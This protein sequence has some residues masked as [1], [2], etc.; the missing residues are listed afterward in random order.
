MDDEDKLRVKSALTLEQRLDDAVKD[1]VDAQLIFPN[2]GLL[3][4]ATPDPVFQMA[5]CRAYNRWSAG[6]FDGHMDVLLPMALLGGATVEEAITEAHWAKDHGFKG[7]ALPAQPIF[8]IEHASELFYNDKRYESLWA[9]ARRAGAADHVS[10]VDRAGPP[11]D[12][13][14]RGCHHQLLHRVDEH[15]HGPAD[16]PDR[17]RRVR[18]LPPSGGGQRGVWRGGGSHGFWRR[19]ITL[20]APITCGSGR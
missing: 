18:A 2:K 14:Q 16:Q 1:G 15:D 10:R 20:T 8:G 3:C 13:W 12:G 19:L 17:V 9:R 7:V 11:G 6:Y 4:W 5:M